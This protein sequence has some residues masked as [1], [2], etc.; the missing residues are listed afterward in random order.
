MATESV[1][2]TKATLESLQPPSKPD[3][4]KGGV[5]DTYRDSKEKGLV[6]IV[7]HGGAKTFY[8]Y[9]KVQGKPQRI[10]LG[11]FPDLTVE[12]A[13]EKA[14]EAKA[15]IVAGINP[16]QERRKLKDEL[17]FSE[18][19]EQH[20]LEE[21]AKK[22]KRS[23]KQDNDN[24]KLHLTSFKRKRL[25]DITRA[26]IEKLHASIT[27]GNGAYAANR[28]LA[29]LS[30]IFT[31][32][33]E[34][35]WDGSNPAMGIKK[36]REKSRDRFIQGDEFARFFKAVMNEPNETARDYFLLSLFC[37]QRKSNMLAMRWEQ[38]DFANRHWR[39]TDTKNGEP[40][41][42]ALTEPAL[43]ILERRKKQAT[44]Q[45]KA[46]KAKGDKL[47]KPV[48]VFPS[49]TSESGHYEE[50]K[51]AWRRICKRAKIEDLRIHDIRRTMGSY[52]AMSG[53]G[54]YLIGKALGHKSSAATEIYARVAV[55]PVREAQETAAKRMLEL[56]A[57]I[58]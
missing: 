23:W 7:S 55:D 18:F 51:S 9:Q 44:A 33:I 22:H 38:I 1:R 6:L 54:Q 26:D 45:V 12:R 56:M 15:Q 8:L 29:L 34:R 43:Q 13:R 40:L 27:K 16:N 50:P 31:K 35:G 41:I 49:L 58:K 53:A 25:S 3:D 37:G 5:Y 47:S 19:F 24:Y 17:T 20:Y 28:V 14:L 52:M 48:W 11:A 42:V 36:N 57:G 4:A 46:A 32:A 2:F 39:I 30:V 10:K 21:Y